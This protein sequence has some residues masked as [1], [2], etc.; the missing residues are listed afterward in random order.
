MSSV[1]SSLDNS[2]DQVKAVFGGRRAALEGC[3]VDDFGHCVFTQAQVDL[4][5]L[6]DR[7]SERLDA[8]RI[9]RLHLFDQCKEL[10]ELTQRLL[11]FALRQLESSQMGNTGHIVNRQGH[12]VTEKMPELPGDQTRHIAFPDAGDVPTDVH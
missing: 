11:G 2:G 5:D 12:T 1:N 9:D 8:G 7:M 3:A 6:F 10:I 4:F